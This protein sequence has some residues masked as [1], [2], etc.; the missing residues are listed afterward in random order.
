MLH[1]TFIP[2]GVVGRT[3]W[4][5]GPYGLGLSVYVLAFLILGLLGQIKWS[6]N[7][8]SMISLERW[9]LLFLLSSL[10]LLSPSGYPFLSLLKVFRQSRVWLVWFAIFLQGFDHRFRGIK[11]FCYLLNRELSE[12]RR[13]NIPQRQC[14]Q[15]PDA[16]LGRLRS[17]WIFGTT[18]RYLA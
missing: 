1:A 2:C 14:R 11:L 17:Q 5:P 12:H 9:P 13:H 7:F 4:P 16:V 18:N 6:I 10:L 3:R 8:S 15:H